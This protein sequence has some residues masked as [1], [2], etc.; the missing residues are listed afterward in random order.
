MQV[1]AGVSGPNSAMTMEE[2]LGHLARLRET[3]AEAAA[4]ADRALLEEIARQR[5]GLEGVR[6]EQE[7]LRQILGLLTAPPYFPAWYLG[8]AE[9]P[10][11]C[12]A[13]VQIEGERRVVGW[14]EGL[15]AA[16][17]EPGDEVYLTHEKNCVVG[18]SFM[19][20][21]LGGELATFN[22]TTGAD[23]RLIL[24]TRDEEI[25]ALPTA[26]LRATELR[27]GDTVRFSRTSGV[28]FERIEKSQGAEYLVER[29]PTTRFA[30]VG[31]HEGEIALLR[32]FLSFQL[33]QP[34]IT[35]KYR[36][37][38]K[39]AVLLVGPPGCGKTMLA[40]A[41]CAEAGALA[42]SGRSTFLAVKPAQLSSMWYGQSEERVR[43]VFRMAQ[44][45]VRAEPGAP[46]VIFFDEVDSLGATRGE[47]LHRVDDRILACF[48]AEMQG[49]EDR[50]NVL[51][52]A[53]TNRQEALDPAL[54]RPGRLGDLV[55][56]LRRP[57]RTA[58][59]AILDRKFPADIPYA[60][61]GEGAAAARARL[62]DLAVSALYAQDG[63]TE[64]A[65]LVLRD[66]KTRCVRALDLVSGAHLEAI[67]QNAIETACVREAEGGPG[68]V[69]AGDVEA[70]VADFLTAAPQALTPRN[71][72]HYLDDLPQDVDVVRCELRPRKVAHPHRYRMEV[73]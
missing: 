42:P 5:Q 68:G 72:H 29:S 63:S 54:L 7:R 26:E 66:G 13:L 15:S 19:E 48:L 24:Q 9:T 60:A 8:E 36:L 21:L 1:L 30:D 67:A 40:R 49:L 2:G 73:A 28:A 41:C 20:N 52:L 32:R 62:L 46:V 69:G 35:R 56:H 10:D 53:A 45:A 38:P 39:R 14:S 6:Q 18:K 27:P 59:R 71:A 70:A 61:N 25:V 64:L 51:V 11:F 17:V 31:G 50:G 12:G 22:R 34:E 47:A 55:L 44:E 43:G 58:A 57:G 3:G 65:T 37:P 23:G 16:D 4:A 33:S